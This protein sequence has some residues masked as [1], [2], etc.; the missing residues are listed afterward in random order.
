MSSELNLNYSTWSNIDWTSIDTIK[1]SFKELN[2]SSK[3][4][5]LTKLR[6]YYS[7]GDTLVY[8]D[9]RSILNIWEG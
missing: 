3:E 9:I 4:D 2:L 5:F 8:N 1:T 7:D 6:D